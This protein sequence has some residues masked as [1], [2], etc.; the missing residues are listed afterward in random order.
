MMKKYIKQ[1]MGMVTL[2][3]GLGMGSQVVGDL[4]LTGS[5]STA[6]TS[7]QTGIGNLAKGMK[8]MGSLMGANMVMDSLGMLTKQTKKLNK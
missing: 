2:G 4:G 8:P 1:G 5:A 3:V 7:V 6:A